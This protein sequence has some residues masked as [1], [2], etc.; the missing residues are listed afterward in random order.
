MASARDHQ[1]RFTRRTLLK[2]AA[3]GALAL[4]APA[5]VRAQPEAIRL[6]HITPVA[7]GS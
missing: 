7:S 3:A 1:P 4:G 5:I 6:G 2:T